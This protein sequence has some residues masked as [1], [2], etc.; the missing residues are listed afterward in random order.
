MSPLSYKERERQRREQEI[1]ETAGRLIATHGYADL[2]MD[3][4]ADAIG[5]SKPTLYQH[6]KSKDDLAAQVLIRCLTILEEH[7]QMPSSRSPL[8]RLEMALRMIL[9][10]RFG[11]DGLLSALRQEIIL[12]AIHSNAEVAVQKARVLARLQALVEEAKQQGQ[13]VTTISSEVIVRAMFCLQSAVSSLDPTMPVP[14]K[15]EL[16]DSLQSVIQLFLRGVAST[17]SQK[18]S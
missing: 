11:P 17:L 2:T 15:D 8:E 6:F 4:L 3:G 13:V 9:E 14:S 5:I 12:K 10:A 18:E 7:L 16:A 1:L